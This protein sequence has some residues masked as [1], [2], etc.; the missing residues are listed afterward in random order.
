MEGGPG[1][2]DQ[3]FYKIRK[4]I[5]W[6]GQSILKNHFGIIQKKN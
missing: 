5:F 6:D 2:V 3:I 1:L 4:S